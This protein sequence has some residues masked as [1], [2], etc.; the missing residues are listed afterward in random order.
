MTTQLIIWSYAG[1]IVFFASLVQSMV[2][3]G[4]SLIAM[5]L[6]L[7]LGLELPTAVAVT[8]TSSFVQRSTFA[9]SMREHIP[10]KK[11]WPPILA[12][13]PTLFLGIYVLGIIAGQSRE[14]IR[15][16]FGGLLVLLVLLQIPLF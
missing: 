9:W 2:G 11:L 8:V 6:L 12:S 7:V 4:F 10:W 16:C 1:L 15:Q 13:I 14:L 5:P 3:F